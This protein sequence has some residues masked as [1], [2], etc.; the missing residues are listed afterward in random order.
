[1]D[2]GRGRDHGLKLTSAG[3]PSLVRGNQKDQYYA[4]SL[5]KLLSDVCRS[6]LSSRKWLLWQR[7]MRLIAECTYFGATT[8][9][10]RQ[11]L[12]EEYSNIIQ[13]GDRAQKF[14]RYHSPSFV[15]R[16]LSLFLQV[17]Y[18]YMLEKLLRWM[19]AW[20][21]AIN[22]EETRAPL[23]MKR[24]SPAQRQR[25][26]KVLNVLSALVSL[27]SQLHMALFY[28]SG[29]F[30][31]LAKRLSGIRYVQIVQNHNTTDR[32]QPYHIL[33]LLVSIQI[34]VQV[35][36]YITSILDAYSP[37]A[38]AKEVTPSTDDLTVRHPDGQ[39]CPSIDM[40]C[41]LCLD[42]ITN[43]AAVPCGHIFCW[44]CIMAW[45]T[46]HHECPVCRSNTEPQ[47]I[48]ILRNFAM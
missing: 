11:T 35:V 44:N 3:A 13:V 41:V 2:G 33:G 4:S 5:H 20:V 28:Y 17:I 15:R 18:P 9:L 42:C 43:P 1:M 7:E 12:G 14:Q 32:S 8:L 19:S 40:K 36:G 37:N 46:Q 38:H 6:V 25:L 29:S 10:N 39:E 45:C 23:F 30:Y 24:M 22:I 47:H 21:D 34:V 26:S 31:H 16:V 48:V 27:V